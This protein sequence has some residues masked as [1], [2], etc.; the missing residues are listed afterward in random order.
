MAIKNRPGVIRRSSFDPGG[1]FL[2]WN[3]QGYTYEDSKADA[4]DTAKAIWGK[5]ITIQMRG[6]VKGHE[7]GGTVSRKNGGRSRGDTDRPIGPPGMGFF[8]PRKK[9]RADRANFL[10]DMGFFVR[11]GAV[12]EWRKKMERERAAKK[13]P[14]TQAKSGGKVSRKSGGKI[15]QGYKAGGSV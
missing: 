7:K 3:G 10:A 2:V 13:T 14:P 12:K 11:P 4:V 9:R 5:G 8:R 15:M 1:E 6:A